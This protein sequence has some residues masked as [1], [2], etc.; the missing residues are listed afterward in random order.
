MIEQLPG[1]ICFAHGP[2][3]ETIGCP[4]WPAC[5]TD[6]QKQEYISMANHPTAP[7]S[8]ASA[9]A[10]LAKEWLN[11]NNVVYD[12]DR[13]RYFVN[14]QWMYRDELLHAYAATQNAE[15]RA[16]VER[17]KQEHQERLTQRSEEYGRRVRFFYQIKEA[18]VARAEAAEARC[19]RLET[20]LRDIVPILTAAVDRDIYPQSPY[21][22]EAIQR[23]GDIARAAL[24][25]RK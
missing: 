5:V 12:G 3:K 2:Y 19:T 25:D 8:A 7:D 17:L 21:I 4:K 9:R 24:S 6:P 11:K 16:E 23:V 14:G 1:G 13:H 20:A 15:L 18:A 22:E 10:P